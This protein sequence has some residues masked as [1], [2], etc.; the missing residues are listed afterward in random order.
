MNIPDNVFEGYLD[1][2]EKFYDYRTAEIDGQNIFD[3]TR[4][5]ISFYDQFLSERDAKYLKD[6]KNLVA[7]I[8]YMSPN[9]Y[10]T[11]CSKYAWKGRTISPESLKQQRSRDTHT[12]NHLKDVLSIYKKRFPMPFINYAEYGQEGLHRMYVAGELLGWDSPKHPVLAIYWAD[13]ERHEREEKEKL[14]REIEYAVEK[15][16]KHA[17]RYKYYDIEELHDQLQI[18]F[19]REFEFF[20]EISKPVSFNLLETSE[21]V[22]LQLHGCE[23]PIPMDDIQLVEKNDSD[24]D[25]EDLPEIDDADLDLD[26]DEFLKKYLK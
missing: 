11:E 17:L 22:I 4:T 24:D 14:Q 19:D 15:S 7:E 10:Y 2:E 21:S 13:E 3:P 18:E 8:V 26:I 20:D 6:E 9:E 25:F 16:V 23:Y 1:A 5:G 12:L